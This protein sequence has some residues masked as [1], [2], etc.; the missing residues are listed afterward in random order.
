MTDPINRN[1]KIS[2]SFSCIAEGKNEWGSYRNGIVA[3][4]YCMVRVSSEIQGNSRYADADFTYDGVHYS[5]SWN[6]NISARG[7]AI[8]ANRFVREV[9]EA[10]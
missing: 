5:R 4:P 6:R 9:V 2:R 8:L 3:T 1:Y 7:L 10:L